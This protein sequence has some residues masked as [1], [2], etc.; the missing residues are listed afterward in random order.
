[1]CQ[2]LLFFIMFWHENDVNCW[3]MSCQLDLCSG[4]APNFTGA[5][6]NVLSRSA[7]HYFSSVNH[8]S[9]LLVLN[10]AARL[11]NQ[12]NGARLSLLRI[13]LDLQDEALGSCKVLLTRQTNKA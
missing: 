11:S 2:K 4:L 6:V 9:W 10:P 7:H 5:L 3:W 8:T 13:L 1:M 12:G